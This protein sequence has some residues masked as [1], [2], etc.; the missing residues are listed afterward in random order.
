MPVL[1]AIVHPVRQLAD[2]HQADAVVLRIGT[3]RMAAGVKG[4]PMVRVGQQHLTVSCAQAQFDVRVAGM[5][6]LHGVQ[7]K[8]FRHQLQ[9]EQQ[10]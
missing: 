7:K 3:L 2:Q 9:P 4:G 8:L 6:V 1:A 10:L 5:A